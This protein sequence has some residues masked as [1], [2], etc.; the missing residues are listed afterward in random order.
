[1]AASV[2][3]G[4][5]PAVTLRWLGA[6]YSSSL[7]PRFPHCGR[8]RHLGVRRPHFLGLGMSAAIMVLYSESL[9]LR[10]VGLVQ[11]FLRVCSSLQVLFPKAHSF[12]EALL[13]L[14]LQPWAGKLGGRKNPGGRGVSGETGLGEDVTD[15][16][17]I[18]ESL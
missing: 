13:A 8:P 16:A 10:V 3:R 9:G 12:A 4:F 2:V 18:A 7:D 11:P 6:L 1:M 14:Y 15:V 17:L 5:L